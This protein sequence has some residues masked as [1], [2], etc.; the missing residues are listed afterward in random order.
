MRVVATLTVVDDRVSNEDPGSLLTS[1][2][3]INVTLSPTRE[4]SLLQHSLTK[5]DYSAQ[6]Y[7]FTRLISKE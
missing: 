1:V 3:P 2:Y 6:S 7:Y 4:F 5:G